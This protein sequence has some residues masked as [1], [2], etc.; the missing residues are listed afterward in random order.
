MPDI[1]SG[2]LLQRKALFGFVV[3]LALT[4]CQSIAPSPLPTAV[5]SAPTP[6]PA[7]R[8]DQLLVA[9]D[10]IA[11]Y[12]LMD[13]GEI[14]H[15][16]DW[17]A[18]VAFA[19]QF[20][21]VTSVPR[22]QLA[23]YPIGMPL[24]R[25]VTG[26]SDP[27]LYVL[28]NGRRYPVT[29]PY[30]LAASGV[31]P[32]EVS[33]L[34][35]D[36]LASLPFAEGGLGSVFA[37]GKSSAV[38][39]TAWWQ[40]SL[41]AADAS[42]RLRVWRDGG[43]RPGDHRPPDGGTIHALVSGGDRLYAGVDNGSVW[44]LATDGRWEP[45]L[46][47][48]NGWVSALA[49][50]PAGI[51]WVADSGHYDL[52]SGRY[53]PGFGLVRLDLD[54]LEAADVLSASTDGPNAPLQ[55]ITALAWNGD[56][57]WV[58][59]RFGGLYGYRRNSGEWEHYT[60]FNSGIAGNAI[61]ALRLESD[62]DLWIATDGGIQRLVDE[63]FDSPSG[64]GGILAIT[65][66]GED[67]W[68]AG[69]AVI[70]HSEDSRAWQIDRAF[71]T[72]ILLDRFASIVLDDMGLPWF[73]GER[74]L[75]RFDGQG[76]LAYD[77]LSTGEASPFIPGKLPSTASAALDLPSPREGYSSWLRAWPRPQADNGRCM[78]YLQ[79]PSG[80]EFEVRLEIARLLRLGV[81]WVLVNYTDRSQ[82][83][84]MAPLFKEAGITGIWRPYVRPYQEY[85]YWA[86]DVAFLQSQGVAP[87]IQ[88]YNEPSLE[89]EWDG[90]SIDQALYQSHLLPAVQE[91][92]D[93]GGL[94]GLQHIDPGWLREDLRQ[95]KSAGMDD[96][97]ERLFFVPH[98]Y[99]ANHPPDYDED[100][101]GVLGFREYAR[102]FEEEIG[103]VP[104]MI[105]GEGGWRLGDASDTRYPAVDEALNRDYHVAVFDWFRTGLL[106]NGEPLPDSLFAFC[107]WLLSDP[108]DPAAWFDS[109][110]GDRT[111]TIQGVAGMPDFVR[112]FSW[113]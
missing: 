12:R 6:P 37:G 49:L 27:G 14:R 98:P 60:S 113:K 29:N 24:T 19:F 64:P 20:G 10:D 77:L 65:S 99:G 23:E 21:D 7:Q 59:T 112:Q 32:V 22:E 81:R 34:P 33:F 72:P 15:V 82:L 96:V 100:I 94:A 35:N 78:H 42:G 30:E 1:L 25:W 50:D 39:A 62:G 90:Q 26:G 38:T 103:F 88:V 4:A 73:V 44:A 52:I 68:T 108:N 28:V 86:E 92:V 56:R 31:S 102:V 9:Q 109:A 45:L 74:R 63:T 53:Q 79:G 80:D 54:T 13:S 48:G 36:L 69:A 89:Q 71:D 55:S 41:W 101:I 17:A 43:W 40:G 93:A 57:L 3:L 67:V 46:Q 75:I 105:A 97:F 66:N 104:P 58:G 76:W 95:L 61:S 51:L 87:Y 11:V 106:S 47:R 84:M 2:C 8:N 16:R 70:A 18:F 85:E 110:S 83:L 5:T 107:P 111:L 91:V